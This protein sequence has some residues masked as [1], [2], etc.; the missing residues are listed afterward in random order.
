[1]NYTHIIFIK[2]YY[3]YLF[4]YLFLYL[5]FMVPLSSFEFIKCDL[6]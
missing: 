1:M 2:F 4:L 6:I 3:E 5:F